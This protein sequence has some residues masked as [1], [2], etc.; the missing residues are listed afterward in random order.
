MEQ[1]I[2]AIPDAEAIRRQVDRILSSRVF[3]SSLRSQRFLRYAVEK[4]LLNAA[5]KEYEIAIEVFDRRSDYD[6]AVDATVRVEASRLRSRLR[7]Y[8]DTEGRLDPVLIDIPKGGYAAIFVPREL[9][10]P[11]SSREREGNADK[12]A[13]NGLP[14]PPGSTNRHSQSKTIGRK[15]LLAT[16]AT[17]CVVGAIFSGSLAMRRIRARQPIRSLAVLPLQNL[18]GNPGQ[19]YFAEGMTDEL[20]TELAHIRG[21]R[22]ISRTS[23]ARV[24]GLHEPLRQIAGELGVDAVIEGSVL[25]SGDKVRIT[26]QLI[27]ARK[28]KHLWA[29]SFE[30]PFS[31]ILSLQDSIADQIASQAKIVLTDEQS[32]SHSV[33]KVNPAAYDAYLLG[34]YFFQKQDVQRSESYFQQAIAIDPSYASAYAGL[35]AALDA[36]STYQG[37]PPDELLHRALAATERAI[38]LDP[39]NGE[40]YTEL[41]SIQTLYQWNWPNAEENLLRGIALNPSYALGEMKYAVYLDAT[42][43]PEEAAA[44]MHRAVDLDPMSFFMRRRLGATLYLARDYDE[45]LTELNRAAEMEPR[46]NVSY[47]FWISLAYEMKGMKNDAVRD[48]LL[49]LKTVWPKLDTA[50][51]SHIYDTQGWMPYWRARIGALQPYANQECVPYELATG[52]IRLGDYDHAFSFLKQTADQHCVEILWLKVDP[53]LDPIRSDPRF[54]G[55]LRRINLTR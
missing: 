27:D 11:V 4:S 1:E 22:V 39:H 37:G 49:G 42:G 51:L 30:G 32:R 46:Q 47:D 26:A 24:A 23:A 2:G 17:A 50:A 34:L 12:E 52:Y 54:D 3:L 40:A 33:R 20:T 9:D 43:H 55:L 38:Q 28:D 14:S 21:L 48:D 25:R 19:D 31:D 44:H 15:L 8:Y 6:P 18:S 16:L 13:S 41:G 7:E 35:G 36:Q 45:A 5:P 10:T 53:V 29:A